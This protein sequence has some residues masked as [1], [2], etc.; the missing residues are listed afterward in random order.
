MRKLLLILTALVFV[1]G[2]TGMVLA[3]K[4][5]LRK[6]K[7]LYRKYCRVCHKPD[8]TGDRVGKP[9]SPDSK[10]Q[11]Q[12]ERIFKPEKYQELECADQW[13]KLSEDQLR[14]IFSYLHAHAFDSPSPAKCK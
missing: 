13:Q 9:L 5:N 8:A 1:F 6:G 2:S 7:H 14:D 11:A 4:P 10:T 3:K 12:W